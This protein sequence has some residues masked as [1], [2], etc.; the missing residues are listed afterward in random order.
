MHWQAL[1]EKGLIT[2]EEFMQKFQRNG[3]ITSEATESDATIAWPTHHPGKQKGQV[4]L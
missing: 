3:R 2:R 1:I 4:I